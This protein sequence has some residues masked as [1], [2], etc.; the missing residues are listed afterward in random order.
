MAKGWLI[1]MKV[2]D[3][4]IVKQDSINNI[5]SEISLNKI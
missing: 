4:N 2:K 5:I 3:I 1:K